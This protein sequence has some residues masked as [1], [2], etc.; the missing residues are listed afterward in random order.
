MRVVR[1]LAGAAHAAGAAQRKPRHRA[2]SQVQ[3]ERGSAQRA[4][5]EYERA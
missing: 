1:D 2:G 5:H 4:A 3:K